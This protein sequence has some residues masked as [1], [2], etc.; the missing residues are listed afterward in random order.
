MS[1]TATIL[2][3]ENDAILARSLVA[4]LRREGMTPIH[5]PTCEAALDAL[6]TR[7]IDA[8]V[9]DIRLPDGSGEDIFW[10]EAGRFSRTPTIFTTANGEVEQAVRLVKLGA[11]DYLLK[12]YDLGILVTRLTRLTAHHRSRP[13]E[14]VAQSPAMLRVVDLLDRIRD[15]PENVLFS[16]SL[17]SGRQMLA[18]RLHDMSARAASPFVVVEGATL[19]AAH[20]DRVLFGVCDAAGTSSPGLLDT[21]G[22][23]TLLVTDIDEIA[24]D[25][26]A[27]LL[28]FVGDHLYRPV[29]ST[30]ECRFLGRICATASAACGDA[31][32]ARTIGSDL[33]RRFAEHEIAVPPL[34]ARSEDLLCLARIL[35][36][37]QVETF[38][39]RAFG[40]S[41]EAEAALIAHDWPG[42]L[43]ELRNRIVRAAMTEESETISVATLFPESAPDGDAGEQ[44]LEA[45]RR[46]AERHVIEAALAENG[47]RIVE[48]AKAL[49]IS[50]V[51]LWS[52]MKRFGIEKI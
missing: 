2:I 23:G 50:R 52:K 45:A 31:P 30:T 20:G 9:S 46:E 6:A 28:R 42:N 26:Q 13:G 37:E 40:F 3:V 18:R 43:R 12:P 15:R 39:Y 4:Q 7:R 49:G 41:V 25:F 36:H 14:L 5:A 16:G 21:V 24:A 22:E 44:T 1:E 47:G 10:A 51:T 8:V 33:R 29:G 27:R 38:S 34:S 17:D 35:L 32:G 19:T 11:T 48:T